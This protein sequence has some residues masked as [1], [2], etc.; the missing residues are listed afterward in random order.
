LGTPDAPSCAVGCTHRIHAR[1]HVSICVCVSVRCC[2]PNAYAGSATTT[3]DRE[4]AAAS[5]ESALGS[6]EDLEMSTR[7]LRPEARQLQEADALPGGGGA[8]ADAI[9]AGDRDADSKLLMPTLKLSLA[10]GAQS[11]EVADVGGDAAVPS[12]DNARAR[13]AAAVAAP[14]EPA[15]QED[16]GKG[17]LGKK[18]YV[19]M[20]QTLKTIAAEE[21]AGALFKGVVPR[22]LQLGLNHAIRF[23]GY[24]VP[25]PLILSAIPCLFRFSFPFSSPLPLSTAVL[26]LSCSRLPSPALRR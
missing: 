24:Q 2:L 15:G 1:L 23:T 19:T 17:D 16:D 4:S 25:S 7:T 22:V 13:A 26:S 8:G 12:V 14:R 3:L 11:A 21:G 6:G 5:E 20:L 10:R 9:S 18:R